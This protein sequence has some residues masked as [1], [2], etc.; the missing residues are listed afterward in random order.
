LPQGER[1]NGSRFERFLH[2]YL[3]EDDI[4]RREVEKSFAESPILVKRG[5]SADG[6]LDDLLLIKSDL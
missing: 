6:E 1:A 2:L 5:H 3:T 4:R